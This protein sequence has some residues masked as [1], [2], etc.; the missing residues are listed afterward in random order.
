M[1]QPALYPRADRHQ[2]VPM[3]Q[4]LPQVTLLRTRCP[5]PRKTILYQELQNVGCIPS[6]RFLLANVAGPDLSCI[7]NPDF[8]A[9]LLQQFAQPLAV[10][11][12]FHTHQRRDR[13]SSV[14]S[15]RFSVP[16]DQF[17]FVNLSRFDIKN[18]NLLP[19][20]MEIAPYNSH[21]GF[22]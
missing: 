6:V 20:R 11:T 22:S 10:T 18:C 2:L 7:P 16:V 8:V 21:E 13:Q 1:L 17:T 3:N 15:L 9:Y 4:Q 19:T 5:Q 14:K 12:S